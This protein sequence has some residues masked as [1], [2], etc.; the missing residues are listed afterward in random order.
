MILTLLA[1]NAE[2]VLVSSDTNEKRIPLDEF[3]SN[4]KPL[5][6]NGQLISAVAIPLHAKTRCALERV[7]R[8]K[9]SGSIVSLVVSAQLGQKKARN[10][11]IAVYGASPA[12]KRFYEAEKGL[13]DDA[14]TAASIEHCVSM[15]AAE[16]EA[17]S[18]YLGSAE[19]RTAMA[20][21]LTKR[22]LNTLKKQ[23]RQ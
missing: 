16:T 10:L 23:I 14:L 12:P 2:V 19:Y 13:L 17:V 7:A 15:I 22:A 4:G 11:R 20:V 3:L 5:L 6:A 21:T 9:S 18:D 8:T 1:L